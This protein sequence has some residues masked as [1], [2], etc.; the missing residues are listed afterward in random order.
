MESTAPMREA[1]MALGPEGE[2]VATAQAGIVS[3]VSA[4][5]VIS[6]SGAA[7][8]DRL[9]A[10]GAAIGTMGQMMAANSKAQI[11]EIDG[12][13]EAEKRRDGKSAE[14]LNKIKAME[15]KKEQMEKKMF[16]RGS[17]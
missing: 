15:K 2:A 12:Q 10:V 3:L 11:A 5:D 8:E 13:I 4:F 14:S 17:R 6:D 1:L 9:A 16:E 7:T